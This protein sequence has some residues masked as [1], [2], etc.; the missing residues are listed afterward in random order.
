MNPGNC[1][2]CGSGK[3]TT[4]DPVTV[5]ELPGEYLAV[6]CVSCRNAWEKFIRAHPAAQRVRDFNRDRR[7]LE[8][9]KFWPNGLL[10]GT[11][12]EALRLSK[13]EDDI[14]DL[15]FGIAE[16]WVTGE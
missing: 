10:S 4:R 1:K 6:L 16:K 9:K 13:E 8:V 15:L 11:D 12:S 7:V 3:L 14:A 5:F 2:K